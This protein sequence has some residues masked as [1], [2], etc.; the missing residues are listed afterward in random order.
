[1]SK[2]VITPAKKLQGA[3]EVPG[4]KSISHRAVM[5]GSIAEGSTKISNFLM[6]EDCVSTINAFR[7]MGVEIQLP[8]PSS[9]FPV[10]VKGKGLRGLKEPKKELYLGNSGTTIRL[11]M[12]IL[13]GQDFE[14]TLT[15]DASLSKRPMKRVAESLRLMGAQIGSQFPVPSSQSKEIYPPLKIKG[16]YPLKAIDYTLPMPS[17]QVKS[18]ILLAGL[19][20]DGTTTISEPLKSRDHTE[21]MLKEFGANIKVDGLKVSVKRSVLRSKGRIYVPGDISS[22][23][24]F[25]VAALILGSSRLTIKN[26]GVNPTRTGIIDILKAMGGDIKIS[27]IGLNLPEP[28][29]DVTISASALKGIVIEGDLIPRAIDELPIVMV[30]AAFAQGTTVI[31]G[32]G[33]LRVKETDRIE[34]MSGNLKKMGADITI[35]QDNIIIR[36][37]ETLN[38]ADVDSFGDH[39]TAMS[40]AIAGLRAQGR[41]SVLNTDCINT[42]FPEFEGLLHKLV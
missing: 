42:S 14:S 17:A 12:G 8:V 40:M 16:K 27:P 15:G 6:G 28:M 18:A 35:E 29:A 5:F 13:A 38:G 20:A 30:A 11:L 25:M 34:S 26:M 36:G 19:Y 4:D 3:I 37:R 22:A 21:R 2:L 41:T 9:Q 7:A 39:R 1:M 33:E 10:V 24:F 23:A 31:K 32:A